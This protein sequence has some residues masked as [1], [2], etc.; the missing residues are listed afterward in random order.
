M[1]FCN[2]LSDL[3]FDDQYCLHVGEAVSVQQYERHL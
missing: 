3:L 2:S 1:P